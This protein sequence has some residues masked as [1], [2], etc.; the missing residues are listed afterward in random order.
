MLSPNCSRVA[1]TKLFLATLLCDFCLLRDWYSCRHQVF[2]GRPEEIKWG[3]VLW[4]DLKGKVIL[5]HFCNRV[6]R[7]RLQDLLEMLEKSEMI[8]CFLKF[9]ILI[10]L[11]LCQFF[12]AKLLVESYKINC[13]CCKHL[14]ESHVFEGFQFLY[15]FLQVH[16]KFWNPV[17]W[18][19]LLKSTNANIWAN[20][21]V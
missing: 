5:D 20:R 2:L 14:S 16:A 21:V 19:K 13:K 18:R 1:F 9:F 10:L 12:A 11:G 15:S 4:F 17:K 8:T 6:K 7:W 3:T